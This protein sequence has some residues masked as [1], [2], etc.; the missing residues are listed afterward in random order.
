MENTFYWIEF[1]DINSV[2]K[3]SESFFSFKKETNNTWHTISNS[4]LNKNLFLKQ[5]FWYNAI[6]FF[7]H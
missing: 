4:E 2:K 3:I 7:W 6:S 1:N 5:Q